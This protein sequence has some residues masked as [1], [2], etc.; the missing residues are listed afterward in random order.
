MT[1][2]EA[3]EAVRGYL[4]HTGGSELEQVWNGLRREVTQAQI[5]S[6]LKSLGAVAVTL[7]DWPKWTTQNER[8]P[9]RY[10]TTGRTTMPNVVRKSTVYKLGG[11]S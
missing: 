4:A 3:Q 5:R 11:A 10:S 8:I 2:R 9:A 6:A 1:Q 7:G